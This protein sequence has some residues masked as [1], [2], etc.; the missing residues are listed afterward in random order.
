MTVILT[1]FC[2]MEQMQSVCFVKL[3][4]LKKIQWVTCGLMDILNNT[5]N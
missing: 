3:S 4:A 1:L 2:E 5:F